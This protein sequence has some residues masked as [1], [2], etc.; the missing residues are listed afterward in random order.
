M[1]ESYF[2]AISSTKN[3]EEPLCKRKAVLVLALC[4]FNA[5]RYHTAFMGYLT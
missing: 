2:L 3:Y 1:K 5:V 4:E